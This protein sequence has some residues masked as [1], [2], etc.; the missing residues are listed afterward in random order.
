MD[1][2]DQATGAMFPLVGAPRFSGMPEAAGP[3]IR[4][5]AGDDGLYREVSL[6][7]LRVTH[8]VARSDVRLPYGPVQER[9][10]V[11]CGAVPRELL[12]QFVRDAKADAPN[13]MAAV[14]LWSAT[15]RQWRYARRAATDVGPGHIAYKEVPVEEGEFVVLDLHSHG[16][17]EAFF[18]QEDDRDDHGSMRFSGV[19]GSLGQPEITA[20]VRLNLAGKTWPAQLR[21]DGHLEVFNDDA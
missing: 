13:E 21:A 10:E 11:L 18:S 2:R 17:F 19:I 7:W 8:R 14:I 6:P 1:A 3:G 12:K 5:I 9:H 15:E 20:C 4:Y 16:L